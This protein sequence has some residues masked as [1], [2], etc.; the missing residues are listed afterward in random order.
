[1]AGQPRVV[2]I[3]A[4]FGGFWAI[5][6]LTKAPV[7]VVLIDRNNYHTFYPLLYQVG[8]AEL[9]P[10]QIS[11]PVRNFL[12]RRPNVEFLMDEVKRVDLGNRVVEGERHSLTYDYLILAAGNASHFFGVS[13]ALENSLPLRSL[14]EGIEVR[15]HILRCFEQAAHESDP[16]VRQRLLTFTIVGG[17]PTGVEFSGALCELISGP[18]R[19]DYPTL[20]FHMVQIVLLEAAGKLLS[21]MPQELSQYA[22][23]RLRQKGLNLR[24]EALAAEV[25]R[26]VVQLKSGD[27]I[28][29]ETVIWT[30]GVRASSVAE[31]LGLPIN[32]K[33]QVSVGPT[34]QIPGHPE[35]YVVGDSASWEA[36]DGPLP[37]IA[38]VAMQQ[39]GAAAHNIVRQVNGQEPHPFRYKSMGMLAV[40]GRNAAVADLGRVKFTGALAWVLWLAVHIYRLIGFRNRIQVLTD[41]GLAYLSRDRAIRFILPSYQKGKSLV[42][43]GLASST[44]RQP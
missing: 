10:E 1:M 25:T 7:D 17:G 5:R 22:L 27:L 34:L 39:G 21:G 6:E 3:G 30:A 26:D 14:E 35:V 18:M 19:K 28:P 9:G 32:T 40:I 24:L 43:S 31:S 4:G 8:A 2:I 12:R 36:N 41:W 33:G 11:H 29:T 15:N 37:M 16:A 13:G 23:D 38:P 20:D 42:K 44:R